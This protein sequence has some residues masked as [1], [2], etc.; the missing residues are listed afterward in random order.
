MERDFF[1]CVCKG[2][3]HFKRDVMQ[4]NEVMVNVVPSYLQAISCRRKWTNF[5][6]VAA[7]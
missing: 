5:N 4:I 6:L 2:D 3:K 1:T 7:Q